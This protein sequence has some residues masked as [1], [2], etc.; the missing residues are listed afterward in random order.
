MICRVC[1]K[2]KNEREFHMR[3]TKH[4]RRKECR[5]CILEARERRSVLVT[6]GTKTCT[7]CHRDL[8]VQDFWKSKQ[9]KDGRQVYCRNCASTR[10]RELQ[11]EPFRKA[12]DAQFALQGGKCGLCETSDSKSW[13]YDH[14]HETG[15]YRAVLCHACN[16]GLGMLQDKP[17][18]LRKA[19]EYIERF[20]E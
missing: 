11:G 4:G 12:R 8:P 17:W 19:A 15:K 6:E 7:K 9:S 2:D 18:L 13:H 14:D 20:R 5:D 1:G 3:D 16:V 10:F